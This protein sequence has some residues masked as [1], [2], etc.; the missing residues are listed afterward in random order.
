[1]LIPV[2]FALVVAASLVLL[3]RPA[4]PPA[5]PVRPARAFEDLLKEFCGSE[6][7]L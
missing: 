2:V 4:P 6:D 5:R 3:T 7:L 1:M